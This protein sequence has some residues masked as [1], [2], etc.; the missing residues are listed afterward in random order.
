MS[1]E[2][3]LTKSFGALRCSPPP[4]KNEIIKQIGTSMKMDVEGNQYTYVINGKF[5]FRKKNTSAKCFAFFLVT[6]L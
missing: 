3:V 4:E 6:T 5:K 2:N 1:N